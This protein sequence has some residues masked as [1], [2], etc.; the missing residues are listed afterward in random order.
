MR[1]LD[2]H[3]F[4][5]QLFKKCKRINPRTTSN[6]CWCN[7]GKSFWLLV[8]VKSFGSS[9]SMNFRNDLFCCIFDT[10]KYIFKRWFLIHENLYIIETKMIIFY[11]LWNIWINII[12]IK[13]NYLINKHQKIIPMINNSEFSNADTK[14][15]RIFSLHWILYSKFIC[16]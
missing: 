4:K 11:T 15:Q 1:L 13:I 5:N 6:E 12:R 16:S 8:L 10:W 9:I 3:K 14:F 7:I 2:L